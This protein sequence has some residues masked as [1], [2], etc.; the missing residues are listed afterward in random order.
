MAVKIEEQ[1][2]WN[3]S[4]EI[5]NQIASL[6]GTGRRFSLNGSPMDSYFIFKEIRLL[7]NHHFTKPQRDK[8]NLLEKL[9]NSAEIKI[10]NLVSTADDEDEYETGINNNKIR[11]SKL[12]LL[13]N[14]RFLLVER[15]RRTI[16]KML[17]EY[18]YLMERKRD[19]T[20][21]F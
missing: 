20:Q 8:L 17:D 14:K 7:I 4:Q 5:S 21:M 3:L 12:I 6:I 1:V 13:N 16:M 9:I 15:Y 11:R 10:K 18:G 2:S 19:A